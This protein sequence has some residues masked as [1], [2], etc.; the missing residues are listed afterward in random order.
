MQA[1]TRARHTARPR[2]GSAQSASPVPGCARE[3]WDAAKRVWPWK[4]PPSR[5]ARWEGNGFSAGTHCCA[6]FM[7]GCPCYLWA[8]RL[9][10]GAGGVLANGSG[11]GRPGTPGSHHGPQTCIPGCPPGSPPQAK[12]CC[13]WEDQKGAQS[14]ECLGMTWTLLGD[15]KAPSALKI[16]L[17]SQLPWCRAAG[18]GHAD[19]CQYPLPWV[20]QNTAHAGG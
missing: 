2:L 9:G 1:G 4:V 5:A 15:P 3:W 7:R 20:S 13:G 10:P 17:P 6:S 8:G 14:C 16:V 12:P 11:R 19:P 18:G